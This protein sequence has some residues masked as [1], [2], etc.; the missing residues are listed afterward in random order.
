[1]TEHIACWSIDDEELSNKTIEKK[2]N[3]RKKKKKKN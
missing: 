2:E 3:E 1:M